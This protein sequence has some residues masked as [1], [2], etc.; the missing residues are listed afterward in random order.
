MPCSLGSIGTY[1]FNSNLTELEETLG[2]PEDSITDVWFNVEVLTSGKNRPAYGYEPPEY[3]ELDDVNLLS[4]DIE[5]ADKIVHIT[6][7]NTIDMMRGFLPEE[8]Q[9]YWDIVEEAA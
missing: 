5:L 7:Q 2:Y 6:D 1:Q 8:D 3:E 4:I 9:Y